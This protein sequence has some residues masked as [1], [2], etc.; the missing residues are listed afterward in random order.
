MLEVLVWGFGF[1]AALVAAIATLHFLGRIWLIR[2]LIVGFNGLIAFID[3]VLVDYLAH[4]A[5]TRAGSPL[6]RLTGLTIILSATLVAGAAISAPWNWVSLAAGLCLSSAVFRQWLRDEEERDSGIFGNALTYSRRGDLVRE[7]V[8][9]SL[10]AIAIS[11]VGMARIKGAV[12]D[13]STLALLPPPPVIIAIGKE[14]LASLPVINLWP[15]ASDGSDPA[16]EVPSSV[17]FLNRLVINL[18]FMTAM[19]R[20]A[21][22]RQRVAEN[23][24]HRDD[25]ETLQNGELLPAR[26]VLR[27][28][29][30]KALEEEHAGSIQRLVAIARG[31]DDF[32][33]DFDSDDDKYR[34]QYSANGHLAKIAKQTKDHTIVDVVTTVYE[35][36]AKTLEPQAATSDLYWRTLMEQADFLYHIRTFHGA[37]GIQ[38]T[39]ARSE[40]IVLEKLL[41]VLSATKGGKRTLIRTQTRV[42]HT[43]Q[44]L[45]THDR[46]SPET[47]TRRAKLVDIRTAL[48]TWVNATA[49][50]KMSATVQAQRELVIVALEKIRS[51]KL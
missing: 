44:W 37:A 6:V 14:I 38:Q 43:A 16:F 12:I 48:Q 17:I 18:M 25:D 41:K 32:D 27:R 20:F 11:G 28:L 23:R 34:L 24:D 39:R 5:L 45:L 1:I 9:A 35:K 49:N 13:T 8:L 31:Q 10:F 2:R 47:A 46:A 42:A 4:L 36:L 3:S 33:L 15:V 19:F 22:I 40:F 21:A 50:V 29:S 7:A 26:A 30:W 51:A